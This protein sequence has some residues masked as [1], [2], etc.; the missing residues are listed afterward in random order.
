MVLGLIQSISEFGAT[1]NKDAAM[2]KAAQQER[3]QMIK[4]NHLHNM[5]T[6]GKKMQ[7]L[8]IGNLI[9]RQSNIRRQQKAAKA[10]TNLANERATQ[11]GSQLIQGD[12]GEGS[13]MKGRNALLKVASINKKAELNER[14]V[15]T[16]L[17]S[18][19]HNDAI[20]KFQDSMSRANEKIGI[21]VAA[22]EGVT[23]TSDKSKWQSALEIGVQAATTAA[24]MGAAGITTDGETASWADRIFRSQ[25]IKAGTGWF[26]T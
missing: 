18:A 10:A 24:T 23:Y 3:E 25:D 7:E 21:G 16:E 9:K 6:I 1:P 2:I 22:T 4:G 13:T 20:L 11:L 12:T 26:P 15:G 8:S 14:H 5:G 17:A 19:A